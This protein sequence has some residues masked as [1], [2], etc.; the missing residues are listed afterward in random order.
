[1]IFWIVLILAIL[2]LLGF[3]LFTAMG[4][5][6]IVGPLAIMLFVVGG[7][8]VLLPWMFHA[9]DLAKISAQQGIIEVRQ[10][11]VESLNK[12][13]GE[14]DYPEKA[15]ISLDN[16]SPWATI[17]TELSVAEKAL[18]E[19]KEERQIAIR[20]VEARRNGPYSGIITLVGDYKEED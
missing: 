10:E 4:E 17:V 13:L 3:I 7:G 15:K 11:R 6:D 8:G 12:R 1:M 9:S 2:I 5:F 18:A 20:S 16:D 14:F 19:A